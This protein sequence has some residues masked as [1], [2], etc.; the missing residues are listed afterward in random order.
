[1]EQREDIPDFFSNHHFS[2][3]S[4]L[5]PGENRLLKQ[6]GH[7]PTNSALPDRVLDKPMILS[8]KTSTRNISSNINRSPNARPLPPVP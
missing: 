6:K 3:Q 8:A 4:E 1:M 5:Y 7:Y 2:A